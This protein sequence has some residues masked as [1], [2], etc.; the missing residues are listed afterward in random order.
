MLFDEVL[1]PLS[2]RAC[3]RHSCA[4]FDYEGFAEQRGPE[5]YC[6]MAAALAAFKRQRSVPDHREEDEPTQSPDRA[7]MRRQ[8]TGAFLRRDY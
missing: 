2:G 1:C 8:G 7:P 6:L 5:G 3:V 4:L